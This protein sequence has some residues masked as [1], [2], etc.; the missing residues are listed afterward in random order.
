MGISEYVT[1]TSRQYSELLQH[2]NIFGVFLT[3]RQLAF[4]MQAQT[5]TNWC[6]AATSTSVSRYYW[7]GSSWT[8]CRVANG[9]LGFS[10]CCNSMVPTACN[11]PW[12]LDRAL[13]R[14]R[15]FL[16]IVS[17]TITFQQ[18][19]T[20]INAGRPVGARIGWSGGGGHFMVIYGYSTVDGVNYLDID[21][22]IYGKSHLTMADFTSD[23][24]GSG[25]W[26]HTYFT[27]SHFRVPIDY[28]IPRDSILELIRKARPLLDLKEGF[29]HPEEFKE[30]SRTANAS[31]GLAQRVFT[32]GLDALTRDNEASPQPI[33][34][35][36]Y[37]MVGDVPRA[38]FDVSDDDQP[39]VKQM[40]A[41]P[42]ALDLV[43]NSLTEAV[44]AVSRSEETCELRL[45]RI[46]ALNFEAMWVSYEGRADDVL[47]PLRT[48]GALAAFKAVPFNDAIRILQEAAR[49][50]QQMED[51][52]G[53]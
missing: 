5:Q 10:N 27:K 26:T 18:V 31:F 24:Q 20:E 1:A 41:S 46:P 32:L 47:V 12:F 15:N 30:S 43:G 40:S 13:T 16:S 23:Y 52:M 35:R 51:T 11:V 6:W 14:T 50:L 4:N 42:G 29:Q 33:G 19:R 22:P 45:L 17:G 28:F 2:V 7:N 38:Y 48:N 53:A 8:Q 25:S 44:A 3:S 39:R 36:V 49:P 37:E 9:E 21:D 34:L